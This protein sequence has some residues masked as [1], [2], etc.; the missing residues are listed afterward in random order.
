MQLTDDETV[1]RRELRFAGRVHH[2]RTLGGA[3]SALLV[4]SVL[5]GNGAPSWTW[6]LW[7]FNGFL[8]P[9]LA[10]WLTLRSPEP[11]QAAQRFLI[12]DSA[13][14]GMWIAL[15]QFNLVPSA[16]L[17]AMVSMDK[18]AVGGWRFAARTM[19]ALVGTC[20]L[21][22]AATGFP[23]RLESSMANILATL[24]FLFVYPMALAGISHALGRRVARKNR[25]LERLNRIDVLT[26][27]PNRR[28]WNEA[29]AAELARHAETRRPAVLMLL[30]VDNLTAVNA[31]HGHAAGDAVLCCVASVLRARA[32]P[33]DTPA[34]LTGDGFGLLLAEATLGDAA[35]VAEEVR[36]AFV[37]ARGPQAAAEDC[38]LSIGLAGA[39]LSV[40]TAEEWITRA[41]M[42]VCR[43]KARGRDRVEF[44]ASLAGTPLAG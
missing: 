13:A 11:V 34:R 30:D 3:L 20:V 31:R 6:T 27:L 33:I 39:D 22:S 37:A 23:V 1:H 26:G 36:A 21:V 24:P 19:P 5:A 9:L 8:W 4:A 38:T 15:M 12:L 2:V 25:Q 18:I 42:A 43:A 7:A 44:D 28:G 14:A 16:V 35:R 40:V 32:R 29:L 17:L 10:N 41:D